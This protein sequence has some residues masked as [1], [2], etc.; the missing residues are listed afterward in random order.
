[1]GRYCFA[2][3]LPVG[4]SILTENGVAVL[5]TLL[6]SAESLYCIDFLGRKINLSGIS[7]A[8]RSRS[9]QNLANVDRSRGDNVQAILGAIGPFWAKWRLGQV[10][11]SPSFL[12]W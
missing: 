4:V 12:V 2:V 6:L 11:R 3:V 7:P 1:M 5:S 9:G 10:L 8:K